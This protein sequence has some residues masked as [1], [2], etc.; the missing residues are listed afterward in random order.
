MSHT[1]GPW[2]YDDDTATVE[3]DLGVTVAG[4]DVGNL[5]Y[6]ANAALITAAPD[7]YEALKAMLDPNECMRDVDMAI[8]ALHKAEG[9]EP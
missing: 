1:P 5:S 6:E 8:A 2:V 9:R 7:L 4:I 3:S